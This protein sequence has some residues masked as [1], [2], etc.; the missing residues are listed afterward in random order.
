M[1]T[2]LEVCSTEDRRPVVLF[3]LWAKGLNVKDIQK[4]M[5]PVYGGKCLSREA[6][7]NWVEK[8]SRGRS[9]VA[10]DARPDVEMT[11]IRDKRLLC[12]GI[13]RTGK[14]MGHIY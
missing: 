1:A 13:R 6:V 2:V 9:K 10:D 8:I 7:H 11:E 12:C 14:V 5:F 4:E 3:F